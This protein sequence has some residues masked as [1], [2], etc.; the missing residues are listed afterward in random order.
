MLKQE[1]IIINQHQED[2]HIHK[3]LCSGKKTLTGALWVPNLMPL[4]Q[5]KDMLTQSALTQPIFALLH[6]EEN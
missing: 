3:L 1:V 6:T 5:S 2:K 4:N